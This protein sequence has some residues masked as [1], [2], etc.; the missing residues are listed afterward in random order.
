MIVFSTIIQKGGSGKTTSA[1]NIAASYALGGKR[2]LL[3]DLDPQATA[4]LLL[5]AESDDLTI[6]DAFTGGCT[7]SECIISTRLPGLSLA[8][9]HLLLSQIESALPKAPGREET[10]RSMLASVA[11]EYDV[12]VID[13]PPSLG[14]LPILAL[15]ATDLAII[16]LAPQQLAMQGLS[17]VFLTINYVKTRSNAGLRSL[18]LLTLSDKRSR[19]SKDCEESTRARFGKGVFQTVIPSNIITAR[20]LSHL[21]KCGAVVAYAPSS[22]GAVA[23]CQLVD[24]LKK[25]TGC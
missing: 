7:L 20:A 21:D 17:Q 18:I 4:S 19:D 5:G 2:V 12:V 16:P 24:E 8:P 1:V 9:G 11:S 25:E 23:Y 15:V 3:V 13:T 6:Y 10:L 14:L 22:P